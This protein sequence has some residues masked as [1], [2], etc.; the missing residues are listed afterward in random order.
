MQL[1]TL[2]SSI[3]TY[4]E[5]RTL[6]NTAFATNNTCR[7][8]LGLSCQSG[9]CQCNLVSELWY[10][11]QG[12]CHKYLNYGEQVCLQD[13]DCVPSKGLFCNT[14]SV[15]NQCNCPT[16]SKDGMC[17]CRKVV[18]NEFFWNGIQCVAACFY[19]SS[20]ANDYTCRGLINYLFCIN[21][22]CDCYDVTYWS[23][24]SDKCGLIYSLKR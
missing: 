6:N 10:S 11:F 9:L 16:V 15:A 17:D 21:S 13:Q 12:K 2:L 7:V 3:N 22:K 24:S 23:S 5:P 19:G 14:K 4:I 18:G 1:Y 20:C 8:D